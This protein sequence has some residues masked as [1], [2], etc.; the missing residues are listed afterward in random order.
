MKNKLLLFF[1]FVLFIAACGKKNKR[2]FSTWT[3]NAEKFSTN[4]VLATT[5]KVVSVLESNDKYNGFSI[6]FRVGFAMPT[7]G[8]FQMLYDPSSTEQSMAS[9]AFF[10][11]GIGYIPSQTPT[12]FL[13]ASSYNSK[14]RYII[15]PTWF[16][17]YNTGTDSVLIS[18]TFNEP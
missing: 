12:S 13:M 17:N 11:K 8:A 6:T 10:V 1:S 18:G 2:Q 3:M 5:G 16:V 9:I 14:A 7:H 15:E 4:E